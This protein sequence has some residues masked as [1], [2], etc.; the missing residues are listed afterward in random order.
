M[1]MVARV[2]LV[3]PHE[4][5]AT[6]VPG[7]RFFDICRGPEGAEIAVQLEGD[8][9]LVRSGRSRFS[10]STLP[11]ADFPNLDDWQSEVEFTCRRRP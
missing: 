8:R 5:G 11:A 7:K 2:A 9:M 4:A 1:E 3:Q 10:L 6:T